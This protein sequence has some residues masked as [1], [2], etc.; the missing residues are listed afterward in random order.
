MMR[1]FSLV[2][3]LTI[4][5]ALISGLVLCGLGVVVSR[6]TYLVMRARFGR[7]VIMPE[8]IFYGLY[9]DAIGQLG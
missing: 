2:T 3:R 8:I 5:Y 1:R 6:A 4:L 7:L 9:N